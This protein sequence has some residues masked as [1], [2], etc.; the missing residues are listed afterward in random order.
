MPDEFTNLYSNPAYAAV[1]DEL[2]AALQAE[3]NL[4][5]TVFYTC[6]DEPYWFND[7]KGAGY[8]RNGL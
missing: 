6:E 7:G 4:L 3:P 2:E 8:E 1:R 5:R